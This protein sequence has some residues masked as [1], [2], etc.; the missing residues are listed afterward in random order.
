MLAWNMCEFSLK[1]VTLCL[2]IFCSNYHMKK[3]K[4]TFENKRTSF[5]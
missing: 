3:T 1:A 4:R 5:K 2:Y